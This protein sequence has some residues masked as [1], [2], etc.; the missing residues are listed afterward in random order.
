MIATEQSHNWI[1]SQFG[2]VHIITTK[3]LKT[4]NILFLLG[5]NVLY[6]LF[7]KYSIFILLNQLAIAIVKL[8]ALSCK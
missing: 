5:P 2:P 7:T 8:N 3:I 6:S 4:G 1:L